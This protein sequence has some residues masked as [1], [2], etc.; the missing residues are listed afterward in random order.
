MKIINKKVVCI[1]NEL[2]QHNKENYRRKE[3]N[4]GVIEWIANQS[5]LEK[6]YQ[7]LK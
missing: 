2:I 4:N 5:K 3:Y 7:K 6:Q 1:K